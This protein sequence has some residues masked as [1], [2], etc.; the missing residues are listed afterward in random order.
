[1]NEIY[2]NDLREALRKFNKKDLRTNL[3]G[4]ELTMLLNYFTNAKDILGKLLEDWHG[5]VF[6]TKTPLGIDDVFED[7]SYYAQEC[8]R[9]CEFYINII[10]GVNR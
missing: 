9:M 8:C 7:V 6:D 1:M 10:E 3:T 2:V 5:S 4:S